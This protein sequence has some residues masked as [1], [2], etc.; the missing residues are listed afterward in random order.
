LRHVI[1]TVLG[2]DRISP[3][4]EV[5]WRLHAWERPCDRLTWR[6]SQPECAVM[7]AAVSQPRDWLVRVLSQP[8][9]PLRAP[10]TV[11]I[12]HLALDDPTEEAGGVDQVTVTRVDANVVPRL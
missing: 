11:D 2:A 1:L 12:L 3:E 6:G 9:E 7:A 5:A 4:M 8:L 10:V